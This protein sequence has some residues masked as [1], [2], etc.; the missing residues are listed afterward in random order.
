MNSKIKSEYFPIFEILISSN[1]SK[2]LSDILKIFYKIVEKKYIDKDIFNYF[3][4]SEIFRE[5]MNKYLKL[6]QI[7]IINIDEYLVK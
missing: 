4:K 7:D 1:N 5:Y 6:E 3:L 2:K